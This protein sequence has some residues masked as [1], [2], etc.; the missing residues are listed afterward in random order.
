MNWP[1]LVFIVPLV[2]GFCILILKYFL[3]VYKD[4]KRLEAMSQTQIITH[5]SETLNGASTIRAYEGK[6]VRFWYHFLKFE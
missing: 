3:K 2:F 6:V 1:F 5:F 4:L